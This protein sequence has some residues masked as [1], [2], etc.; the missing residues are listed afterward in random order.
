MNGKQDRPFKVF[1]VTC[2]P[3]NDVEADR[4]IKIMWSNIS[5]NFPERSSWTAN[6]F[7]P[8]AD[9]E[10]PQEAESSTKFDLAD[11]FELDSFMSTSSSERPFTS[12]PITSSSP[13][14]EVHTKTAKYHHTG[15]WT[16]K[17]SW[18]QTSCWTFY[19][20]TK[21]KNT[22][23]KQLRTDQRKMLVS[24]STTKETWKE[25]KMV[26]IKNTRAIVVS[27]EKFPLRLTISNCST[28]LCCN[29]GGPSSSEKKF[30]SCPVVQLGFLT[31]QQYTIVFMQGMW[32]IVDGV[33]LK[34]LGYDLSSEF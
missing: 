23:M 16:K 5:T 18:K 7:V 19:S 6:H 14:S 34:G 29:R 21:S 2:S 10:I 24:W 3:R 28:V 11:S 22:N 1:N 27:G 26:S 12:S 20:E 8:L 9:R 30:L 33:K 17:P 15:L 25:R 4:T 31:S 32:H 13:V